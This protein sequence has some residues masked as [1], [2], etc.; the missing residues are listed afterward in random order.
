MQDGVAVLDD[1]GGLRAERLDR[2]EAL[3]LLSKARSAAQDAGHAA[4]VRDE[5]RLPE[6][7]QDPWEEGPRA[8][9]VDMVGDRAWWKVADVNDDRPVEAVRDVPAGEAQAGS[10]S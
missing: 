10:G 2:A 6:G 3:R 4:V 1:F 7:F 9:D 8:L 5:D